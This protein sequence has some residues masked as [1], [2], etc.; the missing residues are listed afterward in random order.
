MSLSVRALA[1]AVFAAVLMAACASTVP[2][3]VVTAPKFPEFIQPVLA[4]ADPKLAALEK[5]HEAGWQFLQAGDLGNAER[6]F[7]TVLKKSVDFYPSETALGYVALAH[8][9]YSAALEQFDKV[10]GSREDYVSALVGRGETLLAMSRNTEALAAFESALRVDSSLLEISRRVEV[11]KAREAQ[12]NV[13]AA[14]RA[15]QEGRLDEASAAFEHAIV[16]SPESA[17]LFRDL[18]EVEA[19]QNK[20]DQ[21]IV[22]YRKAIE[23]DPTDVASRARIGEILEAR[24]DVEGATTIYT[25]AFGLDPSPDLRN[26]L[27]ALEAR[28]AYLRLPLEYR[29]LAERESMTRGDLAALIGIRLE[30][31]LTESPTQP[32]LVTDTVDHWAAKWIMDVAGAGV[33][34]AFDNHTFQPL[35][36]IKRSDLAQAVSRLLHL[37]AARRP[38]LLKEWQSRQAKMADVGVSNLNFADASISV[39]AGIL[40]LADGGLFQLSRSVSGKEAIDAVSRLETLFNASK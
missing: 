28:A 20:T 27:A 18:A 9:D 2:P 30:A 36:E 24:G 33:M 16:T 26:R 32:P 3:P 12:E 40:P 10:L 5:T 34:D 23:L 7:Q 37:I 6:Q 29:T 11:L 13:E 1:P 31:L 15:A 14:R 4:P 35:A 8:K 25:E 39:S 22:H 38:E 19:R 21:A 17:F